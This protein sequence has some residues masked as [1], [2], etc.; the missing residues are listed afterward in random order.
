MRGS[1]NNNRSDKTA[2]EV[3]RVDFV[4]KLF[5]ESRRRRR[6]RLLLVL[7]LVMMI[8]RWDG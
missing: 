7:V 6:R 5:V 4:S 1:N 8:R 2:R 3:E